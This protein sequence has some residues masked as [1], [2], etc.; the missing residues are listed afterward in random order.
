MSY[1]FSNVR[2]ISLNT[3]HVLVRIIIH[4]MLGAVYIYVSYW[5]DFFLQEKYATHPKKTSSAHT[6]VKNST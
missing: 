3:D 1:W 4:C 2:Y 6:Y 5:I